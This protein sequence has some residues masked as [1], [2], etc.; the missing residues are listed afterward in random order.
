M[1]EKND[2]SIHQRFGR[3]IVGLVLVLPLNVLTVGTSRAGQAEV[4]DETCLSCHDGYDAGLVKTGHA[5]TEAN[6]QGVSCVSCHSGGPGH[7]DDPSK[8]KITNPATQD[9]AKTEQVCTTC[10]RPHP[11]L[12]MVG[13]D[14]H[15]GMQMTCTGCH[16]VHKPAKAGELPCQK[17]HVAVTHQFLQRSNH[18]L[19]EGTVSCVSCHDFLGKAEPPM[20][21]GASANCYACHPDQSGPFLFEHEA[22]GSFTTEGSAG[23]VSC[24]APHGS[25]NDRLLT[26]TG[27]NLCKQCHGLPAGHTTAHEGQ[28]SQVDCVDCHSDIHGSY[29]NLF[30][31]DPQ[32][33]T[34]FGREAD[35]CFCHYYR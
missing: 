10:H 29:D 23:C 21:H 18:P 34:K 25:V 31:L 7:I 3:Y 19:I 6:G 15:V 26:Q 32:L 8:D 5:L 27:S 11:G 35:G 9:M 22:T 17:C 14:P 24:H 28:F 12:G 30:L 20:G 1:T 16:S 33:G 13:Q 2:N 4:P